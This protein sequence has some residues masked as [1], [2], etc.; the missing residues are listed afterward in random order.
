LR[1]RHDVVIAEGGIDSIEKMQ[2]CF[3]AGAKH[4]CIG[5]ALTDPARLI[6][7]YWEAACRT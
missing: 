3:E 5:T 7:R 2:R 4:V 6:R 1:E